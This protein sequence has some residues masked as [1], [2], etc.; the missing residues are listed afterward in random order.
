[1]KFTID[2]EQVITF[3]ITSDDIS[4]NII[5]GT[6]KSVHP[7]DVGEFYLSSS[8]HSVANVTNN[9]LPEYSHTEPWSC[10]IL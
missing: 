8:P 10:C 7:H 9:E 1:M 4:N 2:D 6:Y 3:V 5:R